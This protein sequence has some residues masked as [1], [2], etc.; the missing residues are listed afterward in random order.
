[1]KVSELIQWLATQDQEATVEVVVHMD[2]GSYY[3]QGGTATTEEFTGE[4]SEYTD[5]R[6]NQFVTPDQPHFNRRFLLL[7]VYKG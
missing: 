5:F 1:M 7:G 3:E 2:R 4:L 6:E